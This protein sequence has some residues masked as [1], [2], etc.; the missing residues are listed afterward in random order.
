[1]SGSLQIIKGTLL[2][3]NI[4]KGTS[5]VIFFGGQ[6]HKVHIVIANDMLTS[7]KPTNKQTDHHN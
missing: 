2:V 6:R 3:F 7:D 4:V 1:M 5:S